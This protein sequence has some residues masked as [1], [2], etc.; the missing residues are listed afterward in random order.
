M[1]LLEYTYYNP[2]NLGLDFGG[3]M[4][5]LENAKDES[6]VMLH[7]CSHNPTGV[8]PSQAQ[9][10][11]LKDLMVAKKH[12]AFF[13][14]AYQGFTTGDIERDAYSLR[15]FTEKGDVPTMLTQ[16]FAKVIIHFTFNYYEYF[17]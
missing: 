9:W 2:N 1:N 17:I 16:S 10:K 6:V 13:D 8:D 7:V 3:M 12:V 5:D 4:K 14:M 15:L 11:E